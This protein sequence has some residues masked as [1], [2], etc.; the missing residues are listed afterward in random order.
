MQITQ[1]MDRLQA[2]SIPG[3]EGKARQLLRYHE[4]LL[5]WNTR[6][7]LTAVTE[8]EDMLDRHYIDSL[9]IL[10]SPEYLPEHTSLL[11][12]GTGAGLPGL[13]LAIFRPD[14]QVTLMDA[15][16]KRLRFLEAV[17]QELHLVNVRTRHAR[18]EDAGHDKEMRESFH[19]ACARAVAPLPVLAE[20]MLP[21]VRTGGFCL[22]WKGPSATEEEEKGRRAAHLLG[23]HLLPLIP[24]PIPG[25]DWQHMLA[26]IRKER[27]CPRAYP[28]RAGTPSRMPLV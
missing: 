18:A 27:P 13:P 26:V 23:G 10:T 7:D 1:I 21:L 11:D 3:D 15:Q 25:R 14:L 16:M 5:D 9:M 19:T 12:V 6:M 22:C 8:E 28:R 20:Y 4:M 17:I 2:C 24:C